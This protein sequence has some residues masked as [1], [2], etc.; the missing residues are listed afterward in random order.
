MVSR[1]VIWSEREERRLQEEK[2]RVEMMKARSNEVMDQERI[3]RNEA[4]MLKQMEKLSIQETEEQEK[5]LMIKKGEE[6]KK[7]KRK[8]N[9]GTLKDRCDSWDKLVIMESIIP[10]AGRGVGM[11][12]G[13][14]AQAGGITWYGEKAR[15]SQK[16]GV[17]DVRW[18]ISL[19]F[20]TE[21]AAW[22]EE[23][24]IEETYMEGK[25][26]MINS[27]WRE[28][29]NLRKTRGREW[30]KAG[31]KNVD[32]MDLGKEDMEFLPK[33]ENGRI[34]TIWP[35]VVLLKADIDRIKEGL[36]CK[37]LLEEDI[38]EILIDYR[39]R[40]INEDGEQDE[41]KRP[42]IK[43]ISR[44]RRE[45][46][47]YKQGKEWV[48]WMGNQMG[49]K[50]WE[51][52]TNKVVKG[53]GVVNAGFT[54]ADIGTVWEVEG[55]FISE[56]E[57]GI[58][59]CWDGSAKSPNMWAVQIA[60][61]TGWWAPKGDEPNEESTEVWYRLNRTGTGK[62]HFKLYFYN[63]KEHISLRA[64]LRRVPKNGEEMWADYTLIGE[65]SD[66]EEEEVEE[67]VGF[68]EIGRAHV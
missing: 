58:K 11:R 12:V 1:T 54:K 27:C 6:K 56:K 48:R 64:K 21:R 36:R 49:E 57:T 60:V 52:T 38:V 50:K 51:V 31:W 42:K 8:R 66:E 22:F 55:R 46:E 35:T 2:E 14:L 19:G 62:A 17:K 34:V 23:R 68:V 13:D 28:E 65:D 9:K 40:E 30:V 59:W 24:D 7:V 45:G 18:S 26:H 37:E 39:W 3:M 61:R 41:V 29:H 5:D 15:V 10:E 20:G 44:T 43:R 16:K 67:K 33:E 47:W 53:K 25:G 63:T 32:T 4:R